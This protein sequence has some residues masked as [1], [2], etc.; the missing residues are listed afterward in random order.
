MTAVLPDAVKASLA[1]RIPLKRACAPGE[2]AAAVSYLASDEAG[3]ITGQ[4]LG[5]NGGMPR[6]A[7]TASSRPS[8]KAPSDVPGQ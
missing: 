2:I 8:P 4:V 6:M 7:Q 5:V 3:Y 1:D